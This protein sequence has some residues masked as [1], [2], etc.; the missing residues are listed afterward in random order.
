MQNSANHFAN[1]L[2]CRHT[3]TASISLTPLCPPR[4]A[5]SRRKMM[6]R[7]ALERIISF[8]VPPHSSPP[9]GLHHC[10][11]LPSTFTPYASLWN[12]G[13]TTSPTTQS[14]PSPLLF[15]PL[16]FSCSS[17]SRWSC[18]RARRVRGLPIAVATGGGQLL[19]RWPSPGEAVAGKRTDGQWV[20][21]LVS[22]LN[23]FELV[24]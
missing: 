7:G 24:N 16:E 18:R 3:H 19:G 15:A 9:Y 12:G 17:P 6:T 11:S 21:S 13:R 5:H 14:H 2:F 4:V 1:F 20:C 23:F 22:Y 8:T 10:S